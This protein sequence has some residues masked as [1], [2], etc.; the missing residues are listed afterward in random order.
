[1]IDP[2]PEHKPDPKGNV[3]F[4]QKGLTEKNYKEV[5]GKIFKAGEINFCVN[6]SV[7]TSS[8]DIMLFCQENKTLYVDTVTDGWAE[9]YENNPYTAIDI[10]NYANRE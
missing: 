7:E 3:S 1:M 4:I 9:W 8:S 10:S 6:L 5:L 2:D